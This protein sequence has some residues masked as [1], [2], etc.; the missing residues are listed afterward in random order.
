MDQTFNRL[1]YNDYDMKIDGFLSFPGIDNEFWWF[2]LKTGI[3]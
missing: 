3:S 1:I 2:N